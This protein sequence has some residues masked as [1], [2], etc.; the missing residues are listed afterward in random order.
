MG[1]IIQHEQLQSYGESIEK[2]KDIKTR[3]EPDA[4]VRKE[5]GRRKRRCKKRKFR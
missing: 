2:T 1:D 4:T 3:Q 5:K